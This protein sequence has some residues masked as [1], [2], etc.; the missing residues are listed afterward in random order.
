MIIL[1]IIRKRNIGNELQKLKTPLRNKVRAIISAGDKEAFGLMNNLRVKCSMSELYLAESA[2]R[3]LSFN[4]NILPSLF[5]KQPIVTEKFVRL[6]SIKLSNSLEY[7]D[8]AIK[9]N[10][11]KLSNL[12]NY[13]SLIN[14]AILKNNS[15]R[16]V[17]LIKQ[18]IEQYGYSHAILRKS[19]LIRTINES[20]ELAELQ[21]IL[22]AY[23]LGS[24]VLNSL[25]YCYR[26]EQDYLSIKRSVMST[27]NL[28]DYNRFTRDILRIG[29][30]PHAKDE[31]DLSNLIQ[32]CLQSSLVDAIIITK[33]NSVF[34][35]VS[36]YPHIEKLFMSVDA[37]LHSIH[38][39]AKIYNIYNDPEDVFFQRSSAWL[40]NPDIVEYRYFFDHFNDAGDANYFELNDKV[41]NRIILNFQVPAIESIT[42]ENVKI[43]GKEVFK[44]NS[45][46]A[47]SAL[48]NLS[49]HVSKGEVIIPDDTLIKI[50]ENTRDLGRTINVEY[51][52]IMILS[53]TSELAKIILLSLVIKRSK[54]DADNFILRRILQNHLR[55]H[56]NSDLISFVRDISKKSQTVASYIYDICT[57]DFI[58]KLS[59]I[60]T[61]TEQITETRA[62][63]H[64]WMGEVTGDRNYITRAK[65]LRIDH[66]INLVKNELDDNRIYVDTQKF[67]DWMHDEIAQDLTTALT[68]IKH[69]TVDG[70]PGEIQI[71]HIISKCYGEFCSNN[72]FGIA[73]YLGRRLRH[74][75]FK[76]HLYYSVVNAI[77]KQYSDVISDPVIAPLW[78]NLKNDFE[79]EVDL[80]VRDKLHIKSNSKFEGFLD[81]EI[82][83]QNKL[84]VLNGCLKN[85]YGD[86][87]VNENSYNSL[88]LIN[89]YCW[90]LAEID[91]RSVNNY[92]KSKKSDLI[93]LDAL[94]DI[95]RKFNLCRIDE[96]RLAAFSR[97]VHR[98]VNEKLT[99]MYGWFKK[100]QSVSPKASLNLL[101]KAVVAEVQQSY[102]SF[103]PDTH[104]DEAE[105]VEL[106][107]GSYHV[108][109]DA[110]Y[111]I[112]FNAAK[113][114]KPL[115]CISRHFLID[116][117]EVSQFAKVIFSSEILDEVC[118]CAVNNRL[119]IADDTSIDDAQLHE[120][121]SGI[122]KLYHLQKYDKC[123][124]ILKIKCENRKVCIEMIYR[125]GYL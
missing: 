101:Y 79:K 18:A 99:E 40:E 71:T 46:I 50:M 92:L 88:L 63:L 65:N 119:M 93:D 114:G 10:Y 75:T 1:P 31:N 44:G 34:F 97:E 120:R 91:M 53:T 117:D 107:G 4:G 54:N 104:F 98:L 95:K 35:D 24:N 9:H 37:S 55:K 7:I 78:M 61:S 25:L 56:F 105:D 87:E 29:F 42:H 49:V 30:H 118:E 41:L 47:N 74:G 124:K 69:S 32:S 58:S 6:E 70:N 90:R 81:P 15:S 82:S 12:F 28:G 106:V 13:I 8:I 108:L 52:K 36:S 85:I 122:K 48:F 23:G 116:Q 67:L 96:Q 102:A 83:G 89:E 77:S 73:S 72:L 123:F 20:E 109:Y 43:N 11:G 80:I 66:R 111:V 21:K 39:I 121:T 19:L 125:L 112:V 76:G 2:I 64:D 115:G 3:K 110:L 86:F 38:E 17:Q 45:H 14:D 5:P 51:F 33:V 62:A 22:S 57:E 27:K 16:A 26:E 100:P 60:I 94:N 59:H 103:N 113:H 84:E 68:L